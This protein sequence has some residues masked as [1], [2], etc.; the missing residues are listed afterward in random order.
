MYEK[1]KIMQLY[2]LKIEGFRKHLDTEILF[3]DSTFLIGENNVGKSSVL[4]ALE[5]LLCVNNSIPTDEF[6][7]LE[8]NGE[9]RIAV[10]QII[11]TAEFHNLPPQNV[12]SKLLKYLLIPAQDRKDEISGTLGTLQKTLNEL[13]NEVRDN[14]ENINWRKNI[15]INW[16]KN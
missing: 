13:F 4:Y 16:Q 9:K 3:L 11:L 8:E 1:I 7:S 12:L 5:Y 10:D 6:Y 2:S 14:S 15:Q